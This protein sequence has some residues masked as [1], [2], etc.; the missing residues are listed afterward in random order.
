VLYEEGEGTPAKLPL[1]MFEMMQQFV[2]KV[3][4]KPPADEPPPLG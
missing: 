4:P 3:K 1:E 2:G